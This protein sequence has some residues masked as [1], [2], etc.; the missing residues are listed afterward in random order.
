MDSMICECGGEFK[1]DGM[2]FG[3][4]PIFE[5]YYDRVL[6]CRVSSYKEQERLA[7]AHRSKSHPE[8]LRLV[9]WDR[10]YINELKNIHR[11]KEDYKAASYPGYKPGDK[12]AY[13]PECPDAHHHSERIFSYNK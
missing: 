11:H 3:E 7:V 2:L 5:P 1:P 8:G 6:R 12:G 4:Q 10:K 13:K 9:Q